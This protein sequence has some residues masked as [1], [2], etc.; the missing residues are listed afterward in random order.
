MMDPS[1]CSHPFRTGTASEL[2]KGQGRCSICGTAMGANPVI[3]AVAKTLVRAGHG[4]AEA[5]RV[6][7]DLI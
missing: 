5:L 2:A 7:P 1:K 4:E 3:Q 6:T